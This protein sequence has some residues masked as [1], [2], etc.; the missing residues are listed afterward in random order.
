MY[1]CLYVQ[2]SMYM[3]PYVQLPISKTPCICIVQVPAC[4]YNFQCK[5]GRM[6]NCLINWH[7]GGK[8]ATRSQLAVTHIPPSVCVGDVFVKLLHSCNSVKLQQLVFSGR[9][10]VP[11]V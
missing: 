11:N 8:Q 7:E 2:L 9:E 1:N 4:M 5:A 6:Y 10:C 3:W